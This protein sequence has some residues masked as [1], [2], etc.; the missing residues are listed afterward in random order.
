[1]TGS[2]F[3]QTG[4]SRALTET[5]GAVDLPDEHR[6]AVVGMVDQQGASFIVTVQREEFG[7]TWQI[8]GL[9]RHDWVTNDNEAGGRV[10]VSW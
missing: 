10:L 9:V 8:Q 7:A 2:I 4:L 3:D 6:N 5:L 1:M